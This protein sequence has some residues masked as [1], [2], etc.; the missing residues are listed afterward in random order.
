M[1]P[2]DTAHLDINSFPC[3]YDDIVIDPGTAPVPINIAEKRQEYEKKDKSVLFEQSAKHGVDDLV[4]TRGQHRYSIES[5]GVV[6][7]TLFMDDP[8]SDVLYVSLT[9]AA[10]DRYPIFMRWSWHAFL[11]AKMLCIDDPSYENYKLRYT[12]WF[13]GSKEKSYL[14]AMIP[15]IEKFIDQLNVKRQNVIFLGSS[16]GGYASLYLANAIEGTNAFALNPQ[17]MPGRW[18]KGKFIRQFKKNGI[19]LLG[20]DIFHRNNLILDASKSKFFIMYNM[21]S[22]DDVPQ[23][24]LF[25][26]NQHIMPDE[27][28]Y[29]IRQYRNIILWLH[30]SAGARPHGCNPE[31]IELKILEFLLKQLNNGVNI[32]EFTNISQVINEYMNIKFSL[33]RSNEQVSKQRQRELT[34]YELLDAKI[35]AEHNAESAKIKKQLQIVQQALARAET[36]AEINALK[37]EQI[38]SSF[39]YKLAR[40]ITWPFLFCF[41]GWKHIKGV[42]K[43]Q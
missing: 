19:D 7:E 9:C 10:H 20:E 22:P 34:K 3:L 11:G 31:R 12:R 21:L 2:R 1:R 18:R 43:N 24:N 25:C 35:K 16:G 23:F 29:G 36:K 42:V 4:V 40:W 17:I 33:K 5:D 14:Q 39:S 32:N 15:V 27:L 28:C 37:V 41:N 26:T 6:F 8:G 38:T 30:A 13:Y